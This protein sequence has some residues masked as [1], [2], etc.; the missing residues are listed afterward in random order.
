[1]KRRRFIKLSHEERDELNRHLNDAMEGG[2]IRPSHCEFVSPIL[3]VRK[4]D[5]SL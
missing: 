1:M 3:F 2:L 4:V 5:G